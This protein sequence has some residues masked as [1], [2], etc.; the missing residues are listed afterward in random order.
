MTQSK[1]T[2]RSRPPHPTHPHLRTPTSAP[3]CMPRAA[4]LAYPLLLTAAAAA[5]ARAAVILELVS[6][7]NPVTLVS[8]P[9]AGY[10]I[11]GVQLG[12]TAASM[13]YLYW[14]PRQYVNALRAALTGVR[15]TGAGYPP[16]PQP[17]PTQPNPHTSSCSLL[18]LKP[19]LPVSLLPAPCA[20]C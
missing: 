16:Q 11:C 2:V 14:V 5:A 15:D 7:L 20:S 12:K 3:A 4:F 1:A 9:S 13:Y 17:T 6:T 18:S 19:M 10:R 8:R